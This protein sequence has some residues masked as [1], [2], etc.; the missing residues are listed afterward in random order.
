MIRAIDETVQRSVRARLQQLLEGGHVNDVVER[1]TSSLQHCREIVEG[2]L[3]LAFEDRLGRSV[4]AAADL[5]SPRC[6]TSP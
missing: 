2:K 3:D 5:A 1:A 6:S 4:F